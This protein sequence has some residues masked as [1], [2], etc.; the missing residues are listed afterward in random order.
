M[1]QRLELLY[2]GREYS[3]IPADQVHFVHRQ[4]QVLDAH[5]SSDPC[6][7]VSLRCQAFAGTHHQYSQFGV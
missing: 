3:F 5:Q 4:H 1:D 6:V 7:S 2:D